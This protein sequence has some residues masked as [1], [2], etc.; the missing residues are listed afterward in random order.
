[1]I[2]P[3]LGII[4]CMLIL[5]FNPIWIR[6]IYKKNCVAL[7][8][9]RISANRLEVK[10]GRWHKPVPLNERKCRTCLNCLEDEFH[11]LLECPLYNELRKHILNHIN[12]KYWIWQNLL[13]VD[14]RKQ[15]WYY[16][17]ILVQY[18]MKTLHVYN[19]IY[20]AWEENT[21]TSRC[22]MWNLIICRGVKLYQIIKKS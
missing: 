14:N 9:L 16:K 21:C 13:K 19:G 8:R 4:F 11:F 3:V 22:R 20:Y 15:N 10:T 1:M 5:G 6:F 12:G 18:K 2:Q 17:F 7:S